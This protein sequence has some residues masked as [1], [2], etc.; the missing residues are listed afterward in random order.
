MVRSIPSKSQE[1]RPW[2]C[3][4]QTL[5]LPRTADQLLD[6]TQLTKRQISPSVTLYPIS[7]IVSSA[8]FL[9]PRPSTVSQ[10]HGQEPA[11]FLW[12]SPPFLSPHL[13]GSRGTD[14]RS[15]HSLAQWLWNSH[16]SWCHF[17]AAWLGVSRATSLS[18]GSRI[19]NM[20]IILLSPQSYSMIKW[21]ND[22]MHVNY[23]LKTQQV[24]CKW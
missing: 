4:L 9:I 15:I 18:P 12:I 13:P 3:S 1:P 7:S 6:Q 22:T 2:A 10:F 24:L 17:P 5:Y 21:L 14:C 16:L 11:R 20:R 19:R 8:I 23:G